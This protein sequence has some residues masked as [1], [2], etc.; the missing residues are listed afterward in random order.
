M[1]AQRGGKPL[2]DLNTFWGRVR[3]YLELYLIDHGF[4]RILWTNMHEIAP[5]VW[6]SNQ[7][8]PFRVRWLARKGFRS[9][10][11]LRGNYQTA[12]YQLEAE[13]CQEVGLEL[14]NGRLPGGI[15]L[16]REDLLGLLKSFRTM[17]RPLLIHCKS[18]ID[19]TGL[20]SLLYLLAETNTTPEVARR[21]LSLTYLHLRHGRH[22][23]LDVMA[24]SYLEAF[25]KT[26]IALQDWIAMEYD[27][28]MLTSA[29]R[30][31]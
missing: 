22:G 17:E 29:Y 6:R 21:Q 18:G 19:R 25:R 2:H 1:G 30:A 10:L 8:S 9:V 15:L 11:T 28:E 24:D 16:P 3:A 26:G 27:P 12:P 20:A 13:A 5:G 31:E 14:Y 23:I 4:L 7:P